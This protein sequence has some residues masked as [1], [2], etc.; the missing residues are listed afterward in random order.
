[1]QN[2]FDVIQKA[3]RYIKRY[4]IWCTVFVLGIVFGFWL[5]A[6]FGNVTT[7]L[8]VLIADLLIV[9]IGSPIIFNK[10][11]VSVLNKKLEADTY[12]AM[13]S[14]GNLDTPAA[15]WQ[16]YGEYFCGNY[17]NVISICKMKLHDPKVAER[18]R[19]HYLTYLANV[20]FDLGDDENLRKVC[21]QYESALINEKPRKQAK[22]RTYFSRMTFYSL[23]LN[24]DIDACMDWINKP[25]P[26]LITQYNRTFCRARLALMQGNTEEADGYFDALVKEAPQLNYGKLAAE[27]LSAKNP[28]TLEDRPSAFVISDEPTEVTLHPANRRKLRKHLAVC[29]IVLVLM[30]AVVGILRVLDSKEKYDREMEAYRESIRVLVEEDYDGVKILDTFTLKNGEDVIDTMFICQTEKEIVV[31]CTYVFSDDPTEQYYKTMAYI[32]IE[33]L[34]YE[35]SP[36]WYWSFPSKT[37]HNQIESYFYTVEADVPSDYLHL[38]SFEIHGQK[39]YYVI[40]E[41]IPGITITLSDQ[42]Q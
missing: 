28:Q 10:C 21:E 1:M 42:Y 27:R 7:M 39:V 30:Y 4:K 41:I 19:Y 37:S 29:A 34:S 38:S 14:C 32:S 5:S 23:Y 13:I 31:G 26:M 22:F 24:Q 40:T 33:S 9:F 3:K 11:V 12:L 8:S 17:Q 15:I 16:L 6:V 36:L 20:Y 18:Y 35:R 2:D 25:A